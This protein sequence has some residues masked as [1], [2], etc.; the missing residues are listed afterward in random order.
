M[1]R[2]FRLRFVLLLEKDRKRKNN[3]CDELGN[4]IP[5]KIMF[6]SAS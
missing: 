5:Y 2:L 1:F 6:V 4:S 3:E